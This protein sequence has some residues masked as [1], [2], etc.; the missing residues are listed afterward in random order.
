MKR[1]ILTITIIVLPLFQALAQEG[2]LTSEN[3]K[4]LDAS[5]EK[6]QLDLN[7]KAVDSLLAEEFIWVHN[8]AGTVD[9]KKAV[10]ERIN[11]YLKT[12][13]NNTKSRN[14]KDVEVIIMG[15]TGVVTGFT[16]IDR[17]PTPTT[18]KFMRTY[19]ESNGK[20]YL[21]ANQTMAIPETDN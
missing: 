5:W 19:V 10:L 1:T 15:T 13:N 12:N 6:A 7:F 3:L 2:C 14:S 17:G 11:R 9:D 16:I 20:C 18:Y 21:L 4:K 8:H